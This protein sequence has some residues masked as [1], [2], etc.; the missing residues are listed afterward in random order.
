MEDKPGFRL[1]DLRRQLQT[2]EGRDFQ[3]TAAYLIVLSVVAGWYAWMIMNGQVVNP[4]LR[5]GY[6]YGTLVVLVLINIQAFRQRS[7]ISK[8]RKTLM[9]EAERTDTVERLSLLDPLTDTFNTK[10]LER[11]IPAEK[12]RAD[13]AESSLS[14]IATNLEEYDQTATALGAQT[15]E[16]IIKE[17]AGIL[18]TVFRPT[19]TIVRYGVELFLIVMPSTGKNG[20]MVAVKRLMERVDSW[21]RSGAI[22]GYQMKLSFGYEGYTHKT[23][24]WEA[25]ANAKQRTSVFREKTLAGPQESPPAD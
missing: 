24:I 21:N 13:R 10:Y 6:F 9:Q 3:A 12:S 22:P 2:L 4:K 1:Q 7:A 5:D 8:S 14:F 15:G 17:F 23:D 19:D 20:A 16:R 18:K 11:M 25:I